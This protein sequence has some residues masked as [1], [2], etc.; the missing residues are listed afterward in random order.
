MT[1]MC[2]KCGK[3]PALTESV[4]REGRI[5]LCCHTC[6]NQIIKSK[7]KPFLKGRYQ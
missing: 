4:D 3:E 2:E 7:N 6:K 5:I 1:T